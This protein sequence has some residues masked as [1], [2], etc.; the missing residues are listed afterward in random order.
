RA[1]WDLMVKRSAFK[2]RWSF[3]RA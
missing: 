2:V 1:S 3:S